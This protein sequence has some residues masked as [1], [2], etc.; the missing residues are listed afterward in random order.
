MRT[1]VITLVNDFAL[2]YS[3][4]TGTY[5]ENQ[6]H[7]LMILAAGTAS[8]GMRMSSDEV[9]TLASTASG[10]DSYYVAAQVGAFIG[11]TGSIE[12]A[13]G[14]LDDADIEH[15]QD[16]RESVADSDDEVEEADKD[17]ATLIDLVYTYEAQRATDKVDG[18]L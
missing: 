4:R 9:A 13:I 8:A 7:A 10:D 18:A 5:L 14:C 6:T 17:G 3:K 16:W 15:V 11:L 1:N 12:G 2:D